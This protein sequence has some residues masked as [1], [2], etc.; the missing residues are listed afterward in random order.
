MSLWPVL[1][2]AF[3]A[4]AAV[5]SGSFAVQD[6]LKF[7]MTSLAHLDR[8]TDEVF[9][10]IKARVRVAVLGCAY[11]HVHCRRGAKGGGC[12]GVQLGAQAPS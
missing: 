2:C 9:N 11:V 4:A 7:I 6:G 12:R 8:T 10:R 1:C 3:A 5:L